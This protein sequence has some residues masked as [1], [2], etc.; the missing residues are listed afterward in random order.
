M[1]MKNQF[2]SSKFTYS[3]WASICRYLSKN[4]YCRDVLGDVPSGSL[5]SVYLKH[6]VECDID[7][8]VDVAVIENENN[9][10]ST[11]YFQFE[12]FEANLDKV[13]E[14]AKL[15]HEI[16]Y[17][18]DVLDASGGDFYV[19]I[20]SFNDH[21]ETFELYGYKIKTV[22]PHGNPFMER[23]GWDSNKDFFRSAKVRE[24][25]GNFF[26]VI[27]DRKYFFS[28]DSKYISDAGYEW[29]LVSDVSEN[30]RIKSVDLVITNLYELIGEPNFLV[31]S[32]HPHRWRKSAFCQKFIRYRFFALRYFARLVGKSRLLKKMLTPFYRVARRF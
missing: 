6:D 11:F 18:Y 30:D 14:I 20:K 4:G 26:D 5:S 32:T 31:I 28:S 12:V 8:A 9:I 23:K 10:R 1:M 21:I 17:H 22:C 13:H 19:A 27:I 15:G 2:D 25:V 24:Q 7:R 16:A 29:K 3:E